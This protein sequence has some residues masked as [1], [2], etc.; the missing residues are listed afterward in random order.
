L[1]N[2]LYTSLASSLLGPK[3]LLGFSSQTTSIYV[4]PIARWGKF[5]KNV[6]NES[7]LS[8]DDYQL[9]INFMNRC[10]L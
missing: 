7:R 4:I 6:F 5:N 2:F 10:P 1:Y 8:K 3:I 9:G